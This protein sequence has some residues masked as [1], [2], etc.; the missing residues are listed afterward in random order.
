M[1]SYYGRQ[2]YF[3]KTVIIVRPDNYDKASLRRVSQQDSPEKDVRAE[4]YHHCFKSLSRV[5]LHLFFIVN[6][7]L[8]F[9]HTTIRF[10][11]FNSVLWRGIR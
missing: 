10:F 3:D 8:H 11:C 9:K 6:D 4:R 7:S 2:I 1:D 5:V